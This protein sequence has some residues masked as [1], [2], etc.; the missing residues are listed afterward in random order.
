M[1]EIKFIFKIIFIGTFVFFAFGINVYAQT[2]DLLTPKEALWLKER[3]NVIVVYPEQ[4]SPPYS[5]QSPAGS[6]QGLSIDYLELIAE[7]VGA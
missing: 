6:I 3:N 7:K 1:K 4:N 2:R 5:Y